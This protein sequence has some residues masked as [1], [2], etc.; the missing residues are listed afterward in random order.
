MP[1]T[2][3]VDVLIGMI[4]GA[5]RRRVLKLEQS[6]TVREAA[7]SFCKRALCS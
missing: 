2:P 6:K 7:V 1:I 3:T 5:M 4:N